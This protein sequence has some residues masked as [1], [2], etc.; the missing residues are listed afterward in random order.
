[1]NCWGFSECLS[2]LNLVVLTI[3]GG[4][5]IW[6]SWETRKLRI[7]TEGAGKETERARQETAIAREI[8]LHPW[9]NGSKLELD[10]QPGHDILIWLPIK[11][12]GKT[13]A[14]KVVFDSDFTID[15][16]SPVKMSYKNV[17]LAPGDTMR[18]KIGRFKMDDQART[19]R[20]SVVVSYSTY[21]G[22]SGRMKHEFQYGRGDWWNDHG[23]YQ[24]ILS[25]G[26]AYPKG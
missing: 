16:G 22:G 13:P 17:C 3:T 1:M 2:I 9:L 5:I 15:G 8:E 26:E 23:D 12:E 11:N 7:A 20:I 19:A 25:T 4:A 6:Y 18:C 24:I 21:V 14:L 10:K